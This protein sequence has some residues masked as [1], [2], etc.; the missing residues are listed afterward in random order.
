MRATDARQTYAVAVS[1]DATLLDLHL[2]LLGAFEWDG[3]FG[4][5][6]AGAYYIEFEHSTDVY[7]AGRGSRTHL[8][9]VLADG[10]RFMCRARDPRI[11]VLCE[12]LRSYEVPS[13]RH[14]PK[15]LDTD[16]TDDDA[17]SATWHAQ[18]AARREYRYRGRRDDASPPPDYARGMFA[19]IVAGPLLMPSAWF[20]AVAGLPNVVE[21]YNEVAARM[22]EAPDRFIEETAQALTA[23]ISGQTLELWVRGFVHGMALNDAAWKTVIHEAEFR[24]LFMPIASVMEIYSSPDKR[25]WLRD[26]K[27]RA[28]SS[29]ACAIAAVE[30]ARYLRHPRMASQP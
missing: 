5:Q 20:P 17:R 16:G 24:Q 22:L 26:R 29:L 23:D 8:R 14:Y 27:L 25:E 21:K 4:I 3:D 6:E 12:V 1:A 15:V 2:A 9:R 19:A 28:D 11:V 13:R 7:T 18:S 10:T 30:L